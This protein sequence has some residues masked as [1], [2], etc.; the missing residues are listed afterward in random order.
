MTKLDERSLVLEDII[1]K[2]SSE[3]EDYA[4]D[5]CFK[6]SREIYKEYE[7]ELKN[8]KFV[9]FEE[10]AQADF[11]FRAKAA[12]KM[13]EARIESYIFVYEKEGKI[14]DDEDRDE[15]FEEINKT[16]RRQTEQLF[17][18]S[19]GTITMVRNQ[20]S[21]SYSSQM[22]EYFDS[23][24]RQLME[25]SLLHLSLKIHEMK[26]NKMLEQ[27][28]DK[29]YEVLR[30]VFDKVDGRQYIPA[31]LRE[32]TSDNSDFTEVELIKIS[33]YLSGEGL[34]KQIDDSGLLVQLTHK[35]IVEIHNS[36]KNPQKSTEHFP[37]PTIQNF[38]TFNAPVGSVQQGNQ[39]VANVQQ[40]FG[41][42]TEDIIRLLNELKEHISDAN[43]QEGFEYIEG[44]ETEVK[45]EKP[46]E[47]RMKLFLKGLGGVVKDTGK[48]LLIEVGKKVIT[49]E[50]QFPNL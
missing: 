6:K 42:E 2:I 41:M 43:K 32:L 19:Q 36:I 17:S 11:S 44:L 22:R 13:V 30:W 29:Q 24:V 23:Q 21:K 48:E 31:F 5:F 47:S 3:S 50:I 35:G 9:S 40:N 46:S 39:N 1:V 49:G 26:M 38:N 7:L 33:D 28:K 45:S 20:W 15:I 18:G 37:A 25:S 14:I 16:I 8:H 4:N 34:I 27:N 10:T 12:A